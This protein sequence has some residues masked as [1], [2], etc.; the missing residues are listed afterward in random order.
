[1]CVYMYVCILLVMQ[2]FALWTTEEVMHFRMSGVEQQ[3]TSTQICTLQYNTRN[4][5]SF[6][7]RVFLLLGVEE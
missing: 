3:E 4:T 2:F 1:M 5:Y 6:G 7:L